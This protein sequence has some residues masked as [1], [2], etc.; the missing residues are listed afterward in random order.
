MAESFTG[1]CS[2]CG[3]K[4]TVWQIREDLV[5]CERCADKLD[6]VQCDICKD[7]FPFGDV[8]FTELPD[9][10]TVCEYCAEDLEE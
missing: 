10:R 7:F 3:R 1:K 6:W 4:K 8:E 5:L 2:K 9:G